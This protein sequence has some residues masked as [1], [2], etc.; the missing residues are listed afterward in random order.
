MGY[1]YLYQSFYN[2]LKYFYKN[3]YAASY[4]L[5]L[6]WSW[7]ASTALPP[8][9]STNLINKGLLYSFLDKLNIHVRS[10]KTL[11]MCFESGLSNYDIK[12]YN[13]RLW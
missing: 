3:L 12:S 4:T 7:S 8:P 1:I 2:Y 13:N 9:N 10:F 11:V 5:L 6:L